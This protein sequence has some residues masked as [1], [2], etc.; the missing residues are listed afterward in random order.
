M[1]G[2]VIKNILSPKSNEEW[3]LIETDTSLFSL[4]LGGFKKE[5]HIQYLDKYVSMH[6]PFTNRKVKD[7]YTDDEWVYILLEGSWIIA[8]GWTEVNL[9]G[10]MKLGVK[11]S[12]RKEYEDDFFD[13]SYLSKLV[14]GLDGWSKKV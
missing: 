1:I 14:V 2:E 6:L 3:V 8:S 5:G 4:R 7:I 9:L 10:E 12:D 13:K 11:F